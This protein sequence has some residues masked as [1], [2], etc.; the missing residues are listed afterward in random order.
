M[1]VCHM[2]CP[3]GAGQAS[4][5]LFSPSVQWA[6]CSGSEDPSADS[7]NLLCI[8]HV[9]AQLH[10]TAKVRARVGERSVQQVGMVLSPGF[11][12]PLCCH[13]LSRS[14]LPEGHALRRDRVDHSLHPV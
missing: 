11:A 4:Q 3:E 6:G 7:D 13:R 9:A 2:E 12:C 1:T 10:L 5:R 14:A 8:F